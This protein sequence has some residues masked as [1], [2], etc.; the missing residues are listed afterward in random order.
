MVPA[1]TPDTTPVVPPTVAIP[2]PALVHEPPDVV[3]DRLVD[4]PTHVESTPE[5]AAGL[6]FTVT[7][8]VVR[9]PVESEYE[10][11]AVPAELPVTTPVE[12]TDATPALLLLQVPPDVADD[13]V[14]VLPLQIAIVPERDA[15]IGFT[16]ISY[17]EIQPDKSYVIV[18]PPLL[19]PVTTPVVVFTL[20]TEGL[21]DDH[22]PP[23]EALAKE[24]ED[25]THTVLLPV[26]D[27]GTTLTVICFTDAHPVAVRAYVIVE[28]PADP[29]ET[30]PVEE[31]ILA[32]D[33]NELLHVPPLVVFEYVTFA[34]THKALG[35]E[36]DAG[37][38]F[39]VTT[40]VV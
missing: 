30:I 14:V 6:P 25:P 35:P 20:P 18:T 39:T 29:P 33:G 12:P 40:D 16:V 19:T 37:V 13:N 36:I 4:V 3:F 7:I 2:V 8:P 22:V 23:E 15:G 38:T 5:I 27:A 31:P 28:V 10:I 11:V 32:I 34:P 26:I 24:V 9:Q 1:P 17:V 21:L